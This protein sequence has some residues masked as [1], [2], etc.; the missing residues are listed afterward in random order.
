M[1]RHT[2]LLKSVFSLREGDV[3]LRPFTRRQLNSPDYLRW[4]NDPRVTRTIGRF[5]Y[6]FPVSRAKLVQYFKSINTDTTLFLAIYVKRGLRRREQFVGTLKVY[7]MDF[8]ARRASIGIVVGEP[9]AW[10]RGIASAAI[11]AICRFVFDE[12]GFRKVTAGYH[13]SNVGMQRA[14][15]KNDFVVE[16]ILREQLFLAG[17]FVDHVLVCKFGKDNT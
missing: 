5:D 7:D 3:M 13:A 4:M 15:E 6:L 12:L 1:P 16:G 9:R 14:F 8:L 17:K 11:R 2:D 10:G